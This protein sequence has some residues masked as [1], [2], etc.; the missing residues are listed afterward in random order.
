MTSKVTWR[1]D[2]WQRKAIP[3][4]NAGLTAAA[5][6]MADQ[7]VR[8]FGTEGGG[9]AGASRSPLAGGPT[10]NRRRTTGRARYIAAPAGRFPGVRT[11]LLRNSISF[12][13]P[14]SLGSPLRA[15]FGTA[16]KYGRHLE[17]GTSRMASRPW[18]IRSAMMARARAG[19]AFAAVAARQLKASG[20]SR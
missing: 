13:S 18:I 10:R 6:V 15:A 12:A 20:L 2:E 1:A 19:R 3:A 9:V 8:N 16:L 11:G 7:A 5:M 17:F 4:L 14:E